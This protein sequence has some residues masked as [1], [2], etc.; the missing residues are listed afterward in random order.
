M[1]KICYKGKFVKITEHTIGENVFERAYFLD[2]VTIIPIDSD[3]KIYFIREHR[4]HETP[5]ERWKLVT[6]IYEHEYTFE[7]NI[8]RELQEE[9]GY[10]AAV[11]E[12]YFD[13]KTTGTIN[14][15]QH[16]VI[17][18]ELTPSKIPNPDGEHSI[19]E[20]KKFSLEE[21]IE[22]LMSKEFPTTLQ[23]LGLFRLYLDVQ[24]GNI[25]L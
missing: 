22:K 1:E 9:L 6:G 11:I 15:R 5:N 4:P 16:I 18:R 20:I 19:L 17:A 3:G 13:L 12:R 21:I 7:E 25:R 8:N 24:R 23:S 10:R 14:S 2:G